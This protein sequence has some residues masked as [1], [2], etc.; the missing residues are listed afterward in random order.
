MKDF[1]Y[2]AY[3][4]KVHLFRQTTK[5]LGAHAASAA[6]NKRRFLYA[7]L[8]AFEGGITPKGVRSDF[9][10][11]G[12][13]PFNPKG[14]MDDPTAIVED[15]VLP[16]NPLRATTPPPGPMAGLGDPIGVFKATQTGIQRSIST[17]A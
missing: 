14:I 15:E 3:K 1:M 2:T 9:K 17:D 8:E 4:N 10:K 16:T 6:V 11:T 12:I 5:T 7:Y 13:W